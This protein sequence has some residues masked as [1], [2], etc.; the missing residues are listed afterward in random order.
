MI[1]VASK[2]PNN[3]SIS[4]WYEGILAMVQLRHAEDI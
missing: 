3:S 1:Q 4:K 2:S